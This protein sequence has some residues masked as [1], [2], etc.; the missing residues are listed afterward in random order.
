MTDEVFDDDGDSE[1]DEIELE[2]VDYGDINDTAMTVFEDI[3]D[4]IG[5][6]VTDVIDNMPSIGVEPT[7]ITEEQAE[8]LIEAQEKGDEDLLDDALED[9]GVEEPMR[10]EIVESFRG[11]RDGEI[12]PA[13]VAEV[14][15]DTDVESDSQ[16]QSSSGGVSRDEVR[17]MVR[18]ETPSADQIVSQLQQE[19]GGAGGGSGGGGGN[20]GGMTQQ[21]QMA[22]RLAQQFLGNQGGG[23]MDETV[24]EAQQQMQKGM[25]EAFGQMAK[26]MSRPSLGQQIGLAVEESLAQNIADGMEINIGGESVDV[27]P[28]SGQ[29]TAA[30]GGEKQDDE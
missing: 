8:K 26:Q 1:S 7:E 30:D 11:I 14:D 24:A 16:E 23:P 15:E 29:E 10:G 17:R 22:L 2:S 5:Q 19:L 25:A 4:S 28:P 13:D 27:S 3:A 21:Q 20:D 9:I 6:P 12:D 18:E